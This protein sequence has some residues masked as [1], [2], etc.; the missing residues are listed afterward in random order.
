MDEQNSLGEVSHLLYADDAIIFCDASEEEVFHLTAILLWFQN[1]T[2]LK[3]NFDKSKLFPVG[4]VEYM[5]RFAQILGCDWQFL[6]TIYLGLPLGAPPTSSSNWNNVLGKVSS[7]LEVWM[8]SYLSLAGRITLCN[9]VLEI[10]PAYLF[11]LF[12]APRFVVDKLEKIQRDFIWSGRQGENKLHLVPW[13]VC[14]APKRF[15]GLGIADLRIR[16]QSLLCKWWWRFARER[17]AWWRE[18]ISFKFPNASSDWMS[19]ARSGPCGSSIWAHIL[20]TKKLFWKFAYVEAGAGSGVSLWQDVWIKGRLLREEFPRVFA[21]AELPNCRVSEAASTSE[22]RVVWDIPFKFS[23]RGSAEQ[24]RVSLLNLLNGLHAD[25][26]FSG[27]SRLVWGPSPTSGYSA[28]SF[29]CAVLKEQFP[30]SAS[31]P[32]HVI[33]MAVAPPKVCVFL[34]IAFQKKIIT[35]DALKRRGW[36][37]PSRCALCREQEETINHIFLSCRFSKDV[38]RI[39]SAFVDLQTSSSDISDL[40]SKWPCRHPSNAKEWCSAVFLHAFCWRIWLE[41]NSRIFREVHE[42]VQVVAYRIASCI[43]DWLRAAHKVDPMQ[44]NEWLSVVKSRLFPRIAVPVTL[45]LA[46]SPADDIGDSAF[47]G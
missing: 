46:A 5:D 16:N 15:G 1:I 3:V 47:P 30:G 43:A 42:I 23:L 10:Q 2:G 14:K 25:S 8:A 37:L 28:H 24:E 36:F 39:L 9:A 21:A 40:I 35:Q 6:P 17:D 45:P 32:F 20:K 33:W 18:L 41:R 12:N 27:P 29:Y 26:F 34:W 13:D 31:F 44:A 19:G 22:G 7:R 38:W 4:E 11:C